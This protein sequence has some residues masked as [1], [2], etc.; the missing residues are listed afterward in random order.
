MNTIMSAVLWAIYIISLYFVIFWSIVYLSGGANPQKRRKLDDY[1]YL[2]IAIPAWNEGKYIKAAMESVF[3][4]DYPKNRFEMIIID[5]G[6]TDNTYEAAKNTIKKHPQFNVTL[7][8]KKNEGKGVAMNLALSKAKGDYF[9]SLDG[10]SHIEPSAIKKLLP[11]FTS[12]DI[13]AVLP[14]MKVSNPKN[15]LEKIQWYEYIVNMYYKKIMGHLDCIFV[16]PGPFSVFRTH[17]LREVGGFAKE[18]L[19]E[20]LEMT[21]RLQKNHY[22]I[23]QAM[24][25]YV[26]TNV[27]NTMKQ[28]YRQRNR[29][30]KGSFFN[31]L[32]YK[33]MMFNK[34]YGDFGIVQMPVLLVSG[35]MSMILI[36]SAIYYFIKPK[37]DFIKNLS[38]VNFDFWTLMQNF[39]FHYYIID[40]NFSLVLISIIT[41]SL[42]LMVLYLAHKYTKEKIFKQGVVPLFA[43]LFLF[44]LYMGF[45]WCGIMVDLARGKV[46][47]W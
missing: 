6:S 26:Y 29:W 27:P 2:T 5:D 40:K 19:T 11:Y 18:N 45:V 24:D 21:L 8:T 23:L 28:L 10:D 14:C 34:N 41:F 42:S 12:Q 38:Y 47:K 17:V 22:R 36:L 16:A 30:F 20:D 25:V 4:L 9:I 43:F 7:I 39:E 35:L 3:S 15:L 44:Y 33:D 37:F 1:P 31:A 13:A 46:Q 32:A